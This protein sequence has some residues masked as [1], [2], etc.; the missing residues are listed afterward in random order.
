V[1]ELRTL[2]DARRLRHA[3]TLDRQARAQRALGGR[4]AP[5]S[6]RRARH[7]RPRPPARVPSFWSDQHGVRIQYV[8]HA[9]GADALEIDGDPAARDFT[10][11]FT[12]CGRPVAG[13]LVGRPHAL[14]ELRRRIEQATAPTTG[15][16]RNAA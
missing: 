9:H 4:R 16:E 1:H 8:G 15:Q 7:A 13:L 3:R 12:R 10:A 2:D 14:P 11:T 6:R 5:G